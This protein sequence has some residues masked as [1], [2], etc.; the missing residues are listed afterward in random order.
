[1]TYQR[2]AVPLVV[3]L[4]KV[5]LLDTQL[6]LDLPANETLEDYKSRY[7]D[8]HCIRPLRN[9]RSEEHTSELQSQ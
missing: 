2:S 8:E 9:V 6:E 5:D 3:V 7:F 4:T 1:M